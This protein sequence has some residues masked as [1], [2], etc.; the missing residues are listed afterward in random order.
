MYKE[1]YLSL[2]N[3]IKAGFSHPGREKPKDVSQL[4]VLPGLIWEEFES[5]L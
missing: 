4:T 3:R 2:Q 1:I 5:M